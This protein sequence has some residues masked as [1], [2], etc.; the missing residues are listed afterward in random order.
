[1]GVRKDISREI[2]IGLVVPVGER[3]VQEGEDWSRG[4]TE[5]RSVDW[6]GERDGGI[7]ISVYGRQQSQAACPVF[8]A[9][10]AAS[11]SAG[12]EFLFLVGGIATRGSLTG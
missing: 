10:V 8:G 9:Y 11:A 7:C 5:W 1:M 2:W 3:R 4:K 12:G 6:A